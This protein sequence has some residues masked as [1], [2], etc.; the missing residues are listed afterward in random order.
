MTPS[1]TD[2][3]RP[4][5]AVAA[6]LSGYFDA[7]YDS[8]A[9][10][11]SRLFHP[12]AHYVCVS[13]GTLQYLRMDDYLPVVEKRPSP[14]SRNEQRHDRILSI[15]FAGLMTAVARVECSIGVKFFSDFL[16][17]IFIDDQWRIISK[18][19]HYDLRE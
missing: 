1:E 11:L 8:D 18:V 6:I 10:K 2:L 17:L 4:Y 3:N 14:A 16:T 15:E 7:L 9:V 5:D 13:D 12:L 19:F